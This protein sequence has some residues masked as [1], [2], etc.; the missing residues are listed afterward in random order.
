MNALVRVLAWRR[1]VDRPVRSLLTASGVAV[2]V[3]FLFSILSMNAQL[4]ANA[5]DTVTVLSGPRLL[6]V[7]PTSPSGLPEA[8]ADDLLADDRVAAAAPM[9]VVRS[10][11]SNGDH[12][13][14]MFVLGV[15]PAAADLAPAAA[16]EVDFE[17][18]STA[19]EEGVAISRTLARRLH[20]DLD[21]DIT[22]HASTGNIDRRVVAIASSPGIDRING[23]AAALLSLPE[24]QRVFGRTG[25]V[26]QILVLAAPDTDVADLRRDLAAAV[27]G[28]GIVGV[29]GE[30][31][32]DVDANFALMQIFT[33]FIGA[34]VV[35]AALMLVFH[36]MSTATAERRTEIALARS[37]GSTRRQL[38]VVTLTEAGLLGVAGTVV[39]L[40]AGGA[41]A[42][43]A[44]ELT[45]YIYD[46]GSPVDLPTR[47]A[48]RPVPAIVAAVAG[49]GGAVLGAVLPARSA[50]RATPIDAFRPAAAYEWRD[51]TRPK[52][53]LQ[54]A[55]GGA[56][57]V[58]VGTALAFAYRSEDPANPI[59]IAPVLVVYLGAGILV[60]TTIP[61]VAR[62]VAA[63][64]ERRSTTTGRFAADAL[65]AN[66]RR[67][68]VNVMALLLP[69]TTVVVTGVTFGSSLTDI[70]R[71]SRGV[72]ATPFNV[73]A[74]TY[75]GVLGGSVASQPL[76]AEHESVLQGVPGVRAVLP[77]QSA[78]LRLPGGGPGLLYAVPVA[79]A[80]RAGVAESV[81]F[82]ALADDADAFTDGLA[83]GQVAVSR[84]AARNLGLSPG[85]RVTL[86]TPGGPRAFTVAA[87]FD[88]WTWQGT[89][90]VDLDTYRTVWGD[91]RA[92]RYAI[93]P[94]DGVSHAALGR[95]LEAAVSG[96]AMPAQVHTRAE[97]LAELE[98]NTTIFLPLMRG[99]SLASLLFAALAL[100]NAAFTAVTEQRWPLALQQALGMSR[101]QIARTLAL[102]ATAIGVI[103]AV[104]GALVGVVLGFF[105]IRVLGFQLVLRLHYDVPWSLVLASA[106]LGVAVAVVATAYP[107]RIARRLTIIQALR[108]E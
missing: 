48:F 50:A 51:P 38:L 103:G 4:A 104:G 47:I 25:F 57:L 1:I 62:A 98:S 5:R 70:G 53:E 66:P 83:A 18:S 80:A 32:G 37:L 40:V 58:A 31:G 90:A 55:V 13:A 14:G 65:R 84:L 45:R 42:R 3:A 34:F 39:G 27:D 99:M 68:T 82:S 88:D 91:R 9:L 2:G 97:G 59:V 67:T 56:V 77:Y 71:L 22:I 78:Q 61:N 7:L 33:N 102:E 52:R 21:A 30:N 43:L 101:R 86:P 60:P 105:A 15:T 87:V 100:G 35:M 29:P 6:Q 19:T 44:V 49:V 36:T 69:V 54:R 106:V 8:V 64:L 85:S 93:V 81:G 89:F 75:V 20:A 96:A 26:D 72:I 107:R 12:D 11:A 17:V 16:D 79:S 23:G 73:D 10:S 92:Y 24:A 95:S 74:D 76:A 108:F 41:L 28:V 46:L 94:A 63:L